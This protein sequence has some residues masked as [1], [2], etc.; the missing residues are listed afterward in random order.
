MA[1]A[2]SVRRRNDSDSSCLR[3]VAAKR[4]SVGPESSCPTLKGERRGPG[5][6]IAGS[7]SNASSSPSFRPSTVQE[8]RPCHFPHWAF[9]PPCCPPFCT[10]LQTKAIWCPRRFRRLP[11]QR[12]CRAAMCLA[13]PKPAQA[14]RPR[15]RCPCCSSWSRHRPARRAAFARWCWCRHASW[16]RR[17]AKPWSAW[18][19]TCRSG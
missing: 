15:L 6:K 11:F 8:F 10:L 3:F 7:A 19:N 12:F 17:L 13:R 16:R 4:Q 14:K 9:R 5:L 18:P 2:F 1:R